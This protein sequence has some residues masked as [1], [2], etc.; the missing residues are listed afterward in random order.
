M[1]TVLCKLAHVDCTRY[2][3]TI[4]VVDTKL[5][6]F[7]P[8]PYRRVISDPDPTV[9]VISD[10]DPEHFISKM[11]SPSLNFS[12]KNLDTGITQCLFWI[13]ILLVR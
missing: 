8:D 3:D 5:K 13:R 1:L 10:T 2:T 4:C 7:D 6:F 11:V 9:Q 12:S